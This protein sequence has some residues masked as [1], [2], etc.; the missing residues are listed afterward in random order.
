MIAGQRQ[1]CEFS[2]PNA[3]DPDGAEPS[4]MR[5]S[6]PL[7]HTLLL[8]LLAVPACTSTHRATDDAPS[9]PL[10]KLEIPQEALRHYPGRYRYNAETGFRIKR[11]GGRLFLKFFGGVPHE[12]HSV[13]D[14]RYQCRE[15]PTT[16]TFTTETEQSPGWKHTAATL[17]VILDDGS[18]QTHR[19][20]TV[21]QITP[22]EVLISD[23]YE[24]A[25]PVYRTLLEESP[26]APHISERW[27]IEAGRDMASAERFEPAIGL[28]RIATELYPGSA[29]T[30]G[31]V[32]DV[33]RHM[34]WPHAALM[35]YR[36]SLE[37]DP[38]FPS[39]LKAVV[40]LKAEHTA[41][42][43]ARTTRASSGR[44]VVTIRAWIDGTD[45]VK[46][47]GDKVWFEHINH[48]LPGTW[49][50]DSDDSGNEPTII[51]GV[52][53]IPQWDGRISDA[54]TAD[55]ELLPTEG[56]HVHVMFVRASIRGKL[57]M[58]EQPSEDNDYTF[59]M[60]FDD[61]VL[62]GAAWYEVELLY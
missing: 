40:E 29:A 20:L 44:H 30:Y 34:G 38:D 57:V 47:R 59:T 26:D 46:V 32:G 7:H 11:D 21:D 2:G 25:L 3:M 55:R 14:G 56:H 27:L 28:L 22:R 24:K 60:M 5:N 43:Q 18:R 9:G 42:E 51:D 19:R 12:L 4:F 1:N 54:F 37:V 50:G 31:S 58:V 10:P 61:D 33:Y 53:W 52:E 48:S 16:I 17:H 41:R 6:S 23:G 36:T 49:V 45:L 15:M 39:A 35:W 62:H 13:G 8:A